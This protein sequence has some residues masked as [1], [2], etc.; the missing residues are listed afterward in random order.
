VFSFETKNVTDTKSVDSHWATKLNIHQ[1]IGHK[2]TVPSKKIY[3][4]PTVMAFLNRS[5]PSDLKQKLNTLEYKT[6]IKITYKKDNFGSF[7][8]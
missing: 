6:Q 1:P 3:V 5:V 2:T 4:A 8:P 7:N